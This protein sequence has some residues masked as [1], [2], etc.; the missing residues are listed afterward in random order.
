LG[1]ASGENHRNSARERSGWAG[2]GRG[3]GLDSPRVPFRGFVAA[4]ERPVVVLGAQWSHDRLCSDSGKEDVGARQLVTVQASV[5]QRGDVGRLR[6]G[7]EEM[8]ATGGRSSPSDGHGGQEKKFGA[9]E[10]RELA[11]YRLLGKEEGGVVRVKSTGT[12]GMNSKVVATCSGQAV[13]DGRR[14]AGTTCL[15]ARVPPATACADVTA[16]T[17]SARGARFGPGVAVRPRCARTMPYGGG[18][19]WCAGDIVFACS[20]SRH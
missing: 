4:E 1:A 14:A 7:R 3:R 17:N 18:P 11:F 13:N 5:G 8:E 12:R 2:K 19:T 9:M 6:R 15:R 16:S 10:L 20:H